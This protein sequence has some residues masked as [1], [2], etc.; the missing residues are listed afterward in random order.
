[1]VFAGFVLK[2]SQVIRCSLAFA[3]TAIYFCST[4]VMPNFA[5]RCVT[6]CLRDDIFTN[7]KDHFTDYDG[8]RKIK[9]ESILT[10]S[11]TTDVYF[12]VLR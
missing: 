6:A 4:Q 10:I 11:V 3:I 9:L 1:M 2:F 5:W 7:K 8:D 12:R